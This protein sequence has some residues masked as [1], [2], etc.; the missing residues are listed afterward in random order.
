MKPT[1]GDRLAPLRRARGLTQE[2][3]AEAAGV[4]V[5]TIRKIESN[6]RTSARMA[7]LHK[8]AQPLGVLTTA[9]VGDATEATTQRDPDDD[10]LGLLDLRRVLT[11]ARGL[12]GFAVAD[13]L[14]GPL[15]LDGVRSSL[16]Y[17][18]EL[19]HRDKYRGVLQALPPL[20]TEARLVAETSTGD[21]QGHAYG[22][23]AGAYRMA[24]KTLLQLR[25]LDLAHIALASALDAAE[26]S[27]DPNRAG[28]SA[29]RT[30]CWLLTRQGRFADAEQLAVAT[31]DEVEPRLSRATPGQLANWGWLLLYASGAAARDNRP[32]DARA[33]LDTAAAAALRLGQLPPIEYEDVEM[34]GF[35]TPKVAMMRVEAAV[36]AGEPGQALD[37]AE[38]VEPSTAPTPSCRYRHRLD[39]AWSHL[40]TGGNAKAGEVLMDLGRKAPSWMRQQRYARDLVGELAATRRRAMGEELSELTALVGADAL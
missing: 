1:I 25:R 39:V 37:L 3:L 23:L 22:L 24:G 9:L 38:Q 21:D 2:Q 18:D 29:V 7:T 15:T 19:Y 20:L 6:E 33:Q 8:L 36:V 10:E 35:S 14:D 12:A 40:A 34:G 13:D 17:T 32:D 27:S 30:M 4:S 5:G 28:A 11:P 31:A 26:R 16:R